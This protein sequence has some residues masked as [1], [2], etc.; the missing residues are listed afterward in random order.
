MIAATSS[1]WGAPRAPSSAAGGWF[2][3][4]GRGPI[5]SAA[6]NPSSAR[7]TVV[8]MSAWTFS[9]G[10]IGGIVA[11][12]LLAI[13]LF[14]LAA[15]RESRTV[16]L[17]DAATHS[18]LC[19]PAAPPGI[20]PR[21]AARG[22]AATG[23]ADSVLGAPRRSNP[24]LHPSR[25]I[26][27]RRRAR[28]PRPSMGRP[29]RRPRGDRTPL[30]GR[31]RGT[32]RCH[33]VRQFRQRRA[34]PHEPRVSSRQ[35]PDGSTRVRPQRTCLT[36]RSSSVR[37]PTP[38]SPPSAPSADALHWTHIGHAPRMKKARELRFRRSGAILC[39]WAILGLNQ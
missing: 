30:A 27:R 9:G 26:R 12:W 36:Q 35:R 1:W 20:R 11:V 17:R 24:R 13:L 28:G 25:R 3:L 38:E 39:W 6:G 7:R 34:L 5:E 15:R 8:L 16:N 32:R 10:L 4:A 14:W 19:A 33:C 22:T 21:F 29:T 23:R 31:T 37:E 2:G 18:Q